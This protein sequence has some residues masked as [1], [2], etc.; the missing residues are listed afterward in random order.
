MVKKVEPSAHTWL[1]V[2]EDEEGRGG[3]YG[4]V[5][6]T[7]KCSSVSVKE[8]GEENVLCG[9]NLDVT[10][11][12]SGFAS[13]CETAVKML[14]GGGRMVQ[15]GLCIGENNA[16]LI[17]MGLVAA[18]EIAIVGSHGFDGANGDMD[19]ILEMVVA[20]TLQPEKLIEREVS[21]SEGVKVLRKMSEE[22]P[23]GVVMIT[24]FD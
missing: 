10:I 24:R 3:G 5:E 19:K 9:S 2:K 11:E 1:L 6:F 7:S 15:A 21:L 20:G 14:K 23:T 16:P 8:S 4:L 17:P 18:K 13:G 12:C 22:S